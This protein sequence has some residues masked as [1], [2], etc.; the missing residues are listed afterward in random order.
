MCLMPVT[1]GPNATL[2]LGGKR[3]QV[4]GEMMEQ[5]L[6]REGQNLTAGLRPEHWHLAPATN[7]N[8]K[9]KVSHCERL[10]NEQILTCRLEDGGHLIQ[11]RSTPEVNVNPGDQINLE[12]DPT[13]WRLFDDDGEA[14][15][16]QQLSAL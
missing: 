1:V 11:V 12:S 9:A 8:L 14:I 4:E 2:I 16:D 6:R 5:L 15:R 3:I 10:G 13:G 7:R